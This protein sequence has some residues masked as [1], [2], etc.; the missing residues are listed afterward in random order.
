MAETQ[1][2]SVITNPSLIPNKSEDQT[3]SATDIQN[4]LKA[5]RALV[6][7]THTYTDTYDSNCNCNCNCSRG[8]L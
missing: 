4:A 3:I 7:H 2:P 1:E 5:L 6:S 8:L